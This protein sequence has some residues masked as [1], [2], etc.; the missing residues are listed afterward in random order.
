MKKL[1]RIVRLWAT[2]LTFG[3]LLTV[4]GAYATW[5]FAYGRLP[6]DKTSTIKDG[7]QFLFPM[8]IGGIIVSDSHEL[9]H[10]SSNLWGAA[11]ENGKV[12]SAAQGKDHLLKNYM[13]FEIGVQNQTGNKRL[14]V[15]FRITFCLAPSLIEGNN[16]WY[17]FQD[18]YTINRNGEMIGSGNLY[19]PTGSTNGNVEL[20]NTGEKAFRS[21]GFLARDYYYYTAT[22]DPSQID[23]FDLEKFIVDPSDSTE[24]FQIAITHS[25]NNDTACFATIEVIATEYQP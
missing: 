19:F 9:P 25:Q 20:I 10:T 6:R 15:S 22:I 14:L 4:G 18:P 11:D 23:G 13:P 16:P 3:L 24:A 17:P 8:P 1:D 7:I 2:I 12:T 5:Y 21:T